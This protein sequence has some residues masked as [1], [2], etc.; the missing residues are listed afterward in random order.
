M[1]AK[2]RKE[3]DRIT[4][5]SLVLNKVRPSRLHH[6]L[7]PMEP[8]FSAKVSG[9]RAWHYSRRYEANCRNAQHSTGPKTPEGKAES[10]MN[11]TTHGI[12]VKQ[13][14]NGATPETIAEMRELAEA[15]T[16]ALKSPERSGGWR[17]TANP[18]RRFV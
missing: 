8:E 9:T 7:D 11:A 15:I 3:M 6:R 14:L 16:L 2:A 17:R 12:F 13:Y 18:L 4:G 10:C 1:T 5:S